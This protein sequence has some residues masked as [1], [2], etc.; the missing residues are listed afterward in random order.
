[1]MNRDKSEVSTPLLGGRR[2][3]DFKTPGRRKIMRLPDLTELKQLGKTGLFMLLCLCSA[4]IIN[5]RIM[6]YFIH[7]RLFSLQYTDKCRWIFSL[8]YIMLRF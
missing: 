5:H 2:A 8:Y 6:D 1:M 4:A 3:E 7:R